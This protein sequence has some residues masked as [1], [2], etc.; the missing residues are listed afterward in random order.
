M[1]FSL[2]TAEDLATTSLNTCYKHVNVYSEMVKKCPEF[3]IK[4][5]LVLVIL[6]VSEFAK[7]KLCV[8]QPILR[9]DLE[10][11]RDPDVACTFK[12]TIGGKFTQLI[13]PRDDDMDISSMTT[14]YNTAVIDAASEI[15][16]MECHR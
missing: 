8:N 14:T 7:K 6:K 9:F 4:Y 3:I 2:F 13:V 1:L 12:R 16:E 10:K 5:E 11:L 15:L